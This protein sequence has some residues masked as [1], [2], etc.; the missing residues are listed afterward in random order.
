MRLKPQ[1]FNSFL[2]LYEHNEAI[3]GLVIAL[4][5]L[6][7][8]GPW[9]FKWAGKT[10]HEPVTVWRIHLVEMYPREGMEQRECTF[11]IGTEL[12]LGL[13]YVEWEVL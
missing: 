9:T 10:D 1:E 7:V 8:P 5:A 13:K 2:E 6:L 3:A 12:E 4:Q 11:H